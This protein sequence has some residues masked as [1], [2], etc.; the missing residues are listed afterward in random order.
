MEDYDKSINYFQRSLQI[1]INLYG[2]GSSQVKVSL[3]YLAENYYY[4]NDLKNYL[5]TQE[6]IM[7]N[8]F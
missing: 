5:E 3:H 7:N 8:K 4:Q 1:R 6:K 2:Q